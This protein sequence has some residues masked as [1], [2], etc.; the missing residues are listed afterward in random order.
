MKSTCWEQ[1]SNPGSRGF[2]FFA[3]KHW[4]AL[5]TWTCCFCAFS[6]LGSMDRGPSTPIIS[7]FS[8]SQGR[9]WDSAAWKQAR[10]LADSSSCLCRAI[11]TSVALS[12]RESAERKWENVFLY[13]HQPQAWSLNY[14]PNK[15]QEMAPRSVFKYFFNVKNN[16][17][18]ILTE[19]TQ[20]VLYLDCRGGCMKLDMG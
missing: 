20:T 12:H 18:L 7:S 14:V 3:L 8:I 4:A 17:H 10:W 9:S 16:L 6:M 19:V 2:S 1:R 5:L 15:L 11:V 13:S